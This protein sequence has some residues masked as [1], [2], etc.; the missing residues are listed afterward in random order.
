MSMSISTS[1][2]VLHRPNTLENR[3]CRGRYVRDCPVESRSLGVHWAYSFVMESPHHFII[4]PTPCR[5][6]LPGPHRPRTRRQRNR[7]LENGRPSLRI[8]FA[9]LLTLPGP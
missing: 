3:G 5:D 7:R 8:A 9:V 4:L 2:T 6:L 1:G